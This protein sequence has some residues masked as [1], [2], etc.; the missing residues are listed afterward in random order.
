M[1][2]RFAWSQT[3]YNWNRY[4]DPKV[5]RYI[6]SDP[7]G[8]AGGLNTYGYVEGNPLVYI[9]PE[10]LL[11]GCPGIGTRPGISPG[12]GSGGGVGGGLGAPA[13][14]LPPLGPIAPI[15]TLPP[16]NGT[17]SGTDNGTDTK[18]KQCEDEDDDNGCELRRNSLVLEHIRIENNMTKYPID[19]LTKRR[20]NRAADKYNRDCVPKGFPPITYRFD[21]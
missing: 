6:T 15:F 4:Y 1:S 11:L 9:D 21:V 3:V 10:G 14:R 8:L 17:D 7:I 19:D 5:G 20:W 12:C 16:I 18:P 13:V 2:S